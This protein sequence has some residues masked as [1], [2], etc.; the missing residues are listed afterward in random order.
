MHLRQRPT[1]R[2]WEPADRKTVVDHNDDNFKARVSDVVTR[3]GEVAITQPGNG[4]AAR[5]VQQEMQHIAYAA[6]YS[7]NWQTTVVEDPLYI[8]GRPKQGL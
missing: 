4:A 2:P 1:G 5:K 8:R 6:G 3:F 7:K